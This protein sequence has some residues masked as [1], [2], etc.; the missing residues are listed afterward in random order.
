MVRQDDRTRSG[1]RPGPRDRPGRRSPPPHETGL[2]ARYLRERMSAGD[3]LELSLADGRTI[4]GP[5]V[6]FD[7]DLITIR[8]EVGTL[9]V[10]KSEIR[11]L[12]EAD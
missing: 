3:P 1:G 6:D 2:E 10:R 8:A 9:V 5:V 12:R 7:Q 4:R 11:Y